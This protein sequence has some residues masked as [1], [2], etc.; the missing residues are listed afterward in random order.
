MHSHS[1]CKYMRTHVKAHYLLQALDQLYLNTLAFSAKAD[2]QKGCILT[3]YYLY[4]SSNITYIT[5]TIIYL[6]RQK[7]NYYFK[8]RLRSRKI[9]FYR[10]NYTIPNCVSLQVSDSI[11]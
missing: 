6:F 5:N 2:F 11:V 3:N 1:H 9:A 4:T 8:S 10:T 7:I